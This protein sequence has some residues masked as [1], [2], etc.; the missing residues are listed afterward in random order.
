MDS[1]QITMSNIIPRTILAS[2]FS[3]KLSLNEEPWPWHD[4]SSKS[5]ETQ[6]S[7]CRWRITF[8]S[9]IFCVQNLFVVDGFSRWGIARL[10]LGYNMPDIW[11]CHLQFHGTQF[12]HLFYCPVYIYN[13][14]LFIHSWIL[15]LFVKYNIFRCATNPN[16]KFSKFTNF[17]HPTGLVSKTI[18]HHMENR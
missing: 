17:R 5:S 2:L 11:H 8:N 13:S 1:L 14:L 9:G 6:S 10:S 18:M 12:I 15:G 3:S 16:H 4:P 7:M